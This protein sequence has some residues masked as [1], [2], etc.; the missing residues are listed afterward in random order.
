MV[1]VVMKVLYLLFKIGRL[2]GQDG[3]ELIIYL[4]IVQ[5]RYPGQMIVG[6]TEIPKGKHTDEEDQDGKDDANDPGTYF[7]HHKT[8]F[9]FSFFLRS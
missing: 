9:I 1:V 6:R 4:V 5:D 7:F 3:I 2:H 8:S